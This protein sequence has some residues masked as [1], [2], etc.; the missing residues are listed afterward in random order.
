M[1]RKDYR[2]TR[3]WSRWRRARSPSRSDSF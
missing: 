2:W 1:L 3:W